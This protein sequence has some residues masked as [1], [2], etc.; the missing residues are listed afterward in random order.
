MSGRLRRCRPSET[1]RSALLIAIIQGV[2]RVAPLFCILEV[3]S[4]S[5]SAHHVIPWIVMGFVELL[6]FFGDAVSRRGFLLRERKIQAGLI[7]AS[8]VVFMARPSRLFPSHRRA[9]E[10]IPLKP[11]IIHQSIK[12]CF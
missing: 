12:Y 7:Q 6:K 2:R 9:V 11:T 1:E 10:D 4:G 8:F 5:V 3:V